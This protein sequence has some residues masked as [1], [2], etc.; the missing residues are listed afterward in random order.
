MFW[1]T[2]PTRRRSSCTGSSRD[3]RQ[4]S[5]G[6]AKADAALVRV[7]QAEEQ[8]GEGGLSAAGAPQ[9]ADHA[10]RVPGGRRCRAARFL[11]PAA[12]R[13]PA[14]WFYGKPAD[15]KAAEATS[16]VA[17]SAG[18]KEPG[19]GSA[20]VIAEGN[21]AEIQPPAAR[22]QQRDRR[23]PK[24]MLAG[25]FALDALDADDADQAGAGALQVLHLLRDALQRPVEHVG[26]IDDHKDRAEGDRSANRT[27]TPLTRYATRCPTANS[28]QVV[29]SRMFSFSPAVMVLRIRLRVRR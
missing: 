17:R 23:Q 28:V 3:I 11:W 21:I 24:L 14:A 18:L 6:C 13:L 15:A 7:V 4:V 1:V 8:A 9:Q 12:A 26:V 10:A 5:R 22:V 27:A 2:M 29:L 20:V 16:P 19:T 25:D